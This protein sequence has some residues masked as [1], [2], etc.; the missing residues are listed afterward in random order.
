MTTPGLAEENKTKPEIVRK[1]SEMA[2]EVHPDTI[3]SGL[4]DAVEKGSVDYAVGL[5]GWFVAR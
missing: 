3:V 1:I 4:V 2:D 5:D